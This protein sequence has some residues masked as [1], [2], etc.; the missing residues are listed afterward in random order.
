[1]PA[2]PAVGQSLEQTIQPRG[3]AGFFPAVHP[4][5]QARFRNLRA[6]LGRTGKLVHDEIGPL[7]Y[8]FAMKMFPRLFPFVALV[9]MALPAVAG[10]W[11]KK[12]SATLD[13]EARKT[14]VQLRQEAA[15]FESSARKEG[16]TLSADEKKYLAL[17]LEEVALLEKSCEAW[18][19]NQK[20]LAENIREKAGEAC[21]KRGELATKLKLWEKKP[22]AAMEDKKAAPKA[23]SENASKLAEIERQQA[24][25]EK[26]KKAL[27]QEQA[28]GR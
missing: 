2:T 25:L 7:C 20:R 18:D 22:A 11:T 13:R 12:D 5:M 15:Y 9:L 3:V 10:D 27:E 16:R 24:E 28:T 1:L 4:A 17:T 8:K 19:K 21:Q 6:S 14:A 23:P 26:K